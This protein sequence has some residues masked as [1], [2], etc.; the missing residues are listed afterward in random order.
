MHKSNGHAAFS[1]AAGNAL[2]GVVA[3]ITYG[4]PKFQSDAPLTSLSTSVVPSTTKRVPA[5]LRE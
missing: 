1:Y 3:D 5:P 2:D 4:A